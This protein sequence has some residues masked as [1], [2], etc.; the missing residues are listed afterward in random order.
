MILNEP[1]RGVDIGAKSEIYDIIND[2]TKEGKSIILISTDLPEI[3]GISD[4]VIVMREGQ[5]VKELSKEEANEE[6]ILAYASGGV[7][8]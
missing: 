5:I 2:L 1:T 6:I 8:G 4:R 3:I 7:N